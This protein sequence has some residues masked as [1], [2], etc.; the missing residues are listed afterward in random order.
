MKE[1]L[2]KEGY[3]ILRQQIDEK[4]LNYL[5]VFADRALQGKSDGLALHAI[6]EVPEF[7]NFLG[8]L[9][10]IGLL[11]KIKEDYFDSPF[12][13][14]S[15][16]CLNNL[17][18]TPN[19][20]NNIHRDIRFF[21]GECNLMLNTLTMLD[22]F[23][24]ENGATAILP[25]SH[26]DKELNEGTWFFDKIQLTGKAGDIIIWNSNL[27]HCSMPNTTNY[28]RRAIPIVFQK[29][30]MK[31]LLDYPKAL[32]HKENEFS[33]DVK[34]LLGFYSRVPESLEEWNGERTYKKNQD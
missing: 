8:H 6:I 26:K 24:I 7:A 27:F 2:N 3:I 25:K 16:S 17:P 11:D 20:S 32:K 13:I 1:Q 29:S 30:S 14:N 9:K 19:F 12:I 4:W 15:F 33:E 23:T 28:N 31:Q 10:I 22:D 18:N 5:R 21:S 34:Q